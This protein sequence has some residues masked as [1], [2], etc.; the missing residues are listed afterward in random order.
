MQ[1][2]TRDCEQ[3]QNEGQFH[4]ISRPRGYILFPMVAHFKR[5]QDHA[6]KITAAVRHQIE[7]P[8]LFQIPRAP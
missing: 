7:K 5:D 6:I 1:P 4:L 3:W 2:Q 8:W